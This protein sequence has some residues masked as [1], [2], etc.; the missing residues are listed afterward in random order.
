MHKKPSFNRSETPH[1][2]ASSLGPLVGRIEPCS[3]T[4]SWVLGSTVF[5]RCVSSL[6]V[7]RGVGVEALVMHPPVA[8]R[9]E[10]AGLSA[11]SFQRDT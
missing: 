3:G 6:G 2:I 4:G 9:W 7:R 10:T 11:P 8:A 1:N 5:A